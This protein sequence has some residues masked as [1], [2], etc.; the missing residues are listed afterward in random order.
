VDDNTAYV[1]VMLAKAGYFNG[2]PERVGAASVEA[3]LQVLAFEEFERA[4]EREYAELNKDDP[5]G[6]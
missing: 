5:A 1:R 2:D 6:G 3:V 4:Y